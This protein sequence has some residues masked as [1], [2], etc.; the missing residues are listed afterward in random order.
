MDTRKA[1]AEYRMSQWAQLIQARLDSGQSI[2][3]FCQSAGINR[4]AYFYW[5]K[6][7]RKA[8]C[9]EVEK[10]E[11]TKGIVPSGWMQFMPPQPQQMRATLDIEINGCHI[12][13]NS[14]TDPVLL[15]KVC[16]VLRSL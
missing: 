14:D 7:L 4:H 2:N 3:A 1:A 9:T 15:K 12:N 11:E 13:V 8:A 6:R 16:L 10:Q 5:Q